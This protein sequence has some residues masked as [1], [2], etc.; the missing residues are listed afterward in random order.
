MSVI[1]FQF[2]K[3]EL[4]STY[5]VRDIYIPFISQFIGKVHT[6]EFVLHAVVISL[7]AS[8]IAPFAGFFASGL[9]RGLKIKD[10]SDTFPG[11]GGFLDRFDCMMLMMPFIYVYWQE[12]VKGQLNSFST[13]MFYFLRL[14]REEQLELLKRLQGLVKQA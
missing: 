1:P 4:A 14:T 9:K 7:F 8:F 11:H 10:F 13:V 2:N 6:S 3:C 5:Q 12:I